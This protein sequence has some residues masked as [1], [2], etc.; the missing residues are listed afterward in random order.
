MLLSAYDFLSKGNLE[1]NLHSKSKEKS[2]LPWEV[3]F[4]IAV[5]VAEALNYLHNECPKP[6]I[7]RDVKSSNILLTED[8]E[9]Q[10]CD[11]GLAIWGPTTASFLMDTDVVGTFGY[12]APEYFMYGKISDKIDVYAFGVVLLEL[13]SGRKP[14]G[15]ETTKGQES[16]VMWAK[17]K[18]ESGN[19][20]S[21]LDPNLDGSIDEAQMHRMALAAKLCLTQAA[22]SRPTM[23]QILSILNG[24]E[25]K[26]EC[27]KQDD[28]E[29]QDDNDDEVY[30]DS[31]AESHLNLAFLDVNDN[32]TSFSS[33]D[34]SSPLSVEE[35]LKK[36]WSRSSSLE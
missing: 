23:N 33:L 27:R 12:L 26:L 30:P 34:Q 20:K 35:Y 28:S 31:S 8:L 16:L 22:R 29:S 6:V 10:L 21:M 18:L 32:S 19:L 3:R 24:E 2:V 15:L 1:E 11:F 4:Q 36:R 14:I 17:P 9:P 13:L 25:G 5:G 7:H